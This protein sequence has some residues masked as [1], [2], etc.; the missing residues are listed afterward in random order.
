MCDETHAGH[1]L[2]VGKELVE[3]H[4]WRGHEG[5]GAVT[6]L[7]NSIAGQ[8]ADG[9]TRCHETHKVNF[10]EIAFRGD[11]ISRRQAAG[12][13]LQTNGILDLS[14]SRLAVTDPRLYQDASLVL[15]SGN[16]NMGLRESKEAVEIRP[17]LR[18]AVATPLCME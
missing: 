14:V 6:P 5:A 11:R 12:F 4:L 2:G 9:V 7:D 3:M 16:G 18:G 1:L 13:D 10:G 17:E 8:L 15:Y